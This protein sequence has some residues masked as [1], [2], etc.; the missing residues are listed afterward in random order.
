MALYERSRGTY[1][2]YWSYAITRLSVFR[3]DDFLSRRK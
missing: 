2:V 3:R 1:I